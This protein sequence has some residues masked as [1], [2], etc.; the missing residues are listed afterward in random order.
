MQ[1]IILSIAFLIILSFSGLQGYS[2][3]MAESESFSTPL[4]AE[5]SV[6]I[7]PNPVFNDNFFVKSETGTI[8]TVEVLNVIGQRVKKIVNETGVPYNI[9]VKLP[10]TQKGMYMI[11]ITFSD[12]KTMIRKILVK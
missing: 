7:Y 4:V 6:L 8:A 1:K 2:Q 10:D 11:R 3:E 9:Y 5:H 12:N